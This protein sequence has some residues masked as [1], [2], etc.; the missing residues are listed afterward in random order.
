MHIAARAGKAEIQ[1]RPDSPEYFW[2]RSASSAGTTISASLDT[3]GI[4][5][6]PETS[7]VDGSEPYVISVLAVP[8]RSAVP[9][10]R[11]STVTTPLVEPTGSSVEASLEAPAYS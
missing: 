4:L 2:C 9:V 6:W 5:A 1:V 3:N 11:Q 10:D 8:E 7:Q